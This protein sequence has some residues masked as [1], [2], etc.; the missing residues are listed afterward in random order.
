MVRFVEERNALR[1]AVEAAITN[2]GE[3]TLGRVV[4]RYGTSYFDWLLRRA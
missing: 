3:T 4:D 2:G 1:A